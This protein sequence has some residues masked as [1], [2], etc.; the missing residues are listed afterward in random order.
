MVFDTTHTG[1]P[2]EGVFS[3][4]HEQFLQQLGDKIRAQDDLPYEFRALEGILMY[5][6]ANLQTEMKVHTNV[7]R[8]L[9]EG[10][11]ESLDKTRLRYLLIQSKKIS[12]FHQ[13]AQLIRDL[14]DG[15]LENDDELNDLYLTDIH[16]NTPRV[17]TNHTE[18]EILLES[19]YNTS[20]E[21]VQT[22]ENLKS[23]I[24]TTEEIINIVLDSNRNE[25]MLLGLKFSTGLLSMGIALYVAAVYGMNLENF[26][27]ET[28]GGFE[29][30][31]VLGSLMML[32]LLFYS[33]RQLHKLQRVTMTG[34]M[35]KESK[36]A[37][38]MDS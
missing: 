17:G 5:A 8:N 36:M 38:K 24:K 6:L 13:K 19:Y 23:Q 11:E 1:A 30:I 31:T 14:V 2:N 12:Q 33:V 22:V 32:F 37:P 20:D 26:I 28:E 10:L 29:V 15:I 35:G 9:L 25:L 18:V 3:T 4:T 16:Q 21:V 7:L 27:E 34:L